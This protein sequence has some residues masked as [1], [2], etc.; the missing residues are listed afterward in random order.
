MLQNAHHYVWKMSNLKI[1]LYF[2][3][4]VQYGAHDAKSSEAIDL[5]SGT[6]PVNLDLVWLRLTDWAHT[7]GTHPICDVSIAPMASSGVVL[8]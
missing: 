1:L 6:E 4:V 8:M 3:I 5:V 2:L 7:A